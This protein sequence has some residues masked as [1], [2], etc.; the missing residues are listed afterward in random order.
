MKTAQDLRGPSILVGVF[1]AM[2]EILDLLLRHNQAL[3][4]IR[5]ITSSIFM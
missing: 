5:I 4:Y 3:F 2:L 1:R